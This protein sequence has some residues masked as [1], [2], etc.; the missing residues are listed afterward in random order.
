MLNSI[1]GIFNEETEVIDTVDLENADLDIVDDSFKIE[2]N[3]TAKT[4]GKRSVVKV[5]Q[6]VTKSVTLSI[7]DA[8]KKG[9]LCIVNLEKVSEEEAK[10]IYS[11]LSGSIYSLDGEMKLIE[12][13]ILLCAPKNFIIDTDVS[14][15]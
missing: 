2:G 9:E 10:I 14:E 5:Y 13:K 3:G 11:T 8:M 12:Q 6:P 15:Q 7:I 1:K 4:M